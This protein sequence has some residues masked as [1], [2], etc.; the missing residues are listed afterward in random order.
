MGEAGAE[1]RVSGEEV[2]LFVEVERT[3]AEDTRITTSVGKC[4][5]A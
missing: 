4:R 2:M 1:M 3:F 5:I